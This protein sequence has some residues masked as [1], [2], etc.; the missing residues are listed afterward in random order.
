MTTPAVAAAEA[1]EGEADELVK[2]LLLL[3]EEADDDVGRTPVPGMKEV[4]LALKAMED[5]REA[6]EEEGRSHPQRQQG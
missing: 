4:V 1:A 3:E 6:G 5:R 2:S